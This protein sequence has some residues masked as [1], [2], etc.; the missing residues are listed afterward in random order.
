MSL[1]NENLHSNEPVKKLESK[2][3]CNE[4]ANRLDELQKP[5]NDGRGIEYVRWIISDLRLGDIEA[6]KT[7]YRNQSD[8]FDNY[9]QIKQ[10]LKENGLVEEIDWD[11]YKDND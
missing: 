10:L 6:A 4:L 8:K 1:E 9:P 3:D 2:E 7:N 5:A 11:K